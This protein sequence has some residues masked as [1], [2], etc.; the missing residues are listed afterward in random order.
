MTLIFTVPEQ[1]LQM[2]SFLAHIT[3][4]LGLLSERGVTVNFQ[5]LAGACSAFCNFGWGA[6]GYLLP[7]AVVMT[8]M[9]IGH[10]GFVVIAG[11]MPWVMNST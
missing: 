5:F 6:M 8:L 10:G 9:L 7:L 1:L 4:G 11:V 3:S 2:G